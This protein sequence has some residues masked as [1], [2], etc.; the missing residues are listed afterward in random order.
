VKVGSGDYQ[1]VGIFVF[2]SLEVEVMVYGCLAS[3]FSIMETDGHIEFS[4][5]LF[6]QF[7]WWFLEIFG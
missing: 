2:G 3:L 1:N 5:T 6:F 7:E 4:P